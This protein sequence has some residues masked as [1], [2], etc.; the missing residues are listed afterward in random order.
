M[1]YR[2]ASKALICAHDNPFNKAILGNDAFYFSSADDIKEKM[3]ELSYGNVEKTM[4][5]N[6]LKKITEQYNW[7]LIVSE[8]ERYIINCYNTARK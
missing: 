4:V 1:V 2:Y 5:A 6:N 7:P 3:E 8:Y